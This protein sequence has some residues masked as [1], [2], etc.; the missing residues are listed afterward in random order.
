MRAKFTYRCKE[1]KMENYID[2]KNKTEH[3]DRMEVVKYCPKCNKRT[4]H[5]EK[6]K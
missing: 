6:K 1:C 2:R 4:T 3:P 5:V